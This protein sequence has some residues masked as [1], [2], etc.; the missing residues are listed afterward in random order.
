MPNNEYKKRAKGNWCQGKD[1]KGDSSERGYSKSEIKQELQLEE[2]GVTKHK[3]KR[4]RNEKARLEYRISWYQQTLEKYKEN[5]SYSNYNNSLR[6][7]L[8]KAQEELQEFLK[9]KK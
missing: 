9:G 1:Y 7:G 3:G 6:E 5:K 2:T 8:K 4:K